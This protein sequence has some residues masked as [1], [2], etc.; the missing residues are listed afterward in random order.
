MIP[1]AVTS[2]LLNGH[3]EPLC[4]FLREAYFAEPKQGSF[5]VTSSATTSEDVVQLA[6]SLQ[7]IEERG[8]HGFRLTPLGYELGNFAKEYCS[9]IDHGRALPEGVT[10]E[11]LTGKRVLDV[12]C[13][14]GR[15]LVNFLK[16]GATG[17]GLDFQENY[18]RLSRVFAAWEHVPPPHVFRGDGQVL[19]FRSEEFDVVF[20]RLVIN[21]LDVNLTVSEF[22]RV[23]RKN[24]TLIL[25]TETARSA[26]RDLLRL[27]W[28]GNR[29][30]V[31]YSLL[32]FA[33]ALILQ[34]TG[35]QFRV[36]SPGR[37][38]RSHSPVWP[39]RPWLVRC[40]AR[41]GF[42]LQPDRAQK[43]VEPFALFVAVRN[44]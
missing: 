24:G 44:G 15:H 30:A 27:R 40:L 41:H 1:H 11:L 36:R 13:S 7:L 37:M 33:N 12:G 35:R 31:A 2:A 42:V 10:P 16:H 3:G 38:H 6:K 19:P 32:G 18:F 21:Y 4:R 17:Y 34:T 20:C 9:W 43:N 22:G 39:T 23:L 8:P 29:R 26:A 28:L 14:S 5:A 25:L